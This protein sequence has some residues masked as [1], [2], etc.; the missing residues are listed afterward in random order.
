MSPRKPYRVK[1]RPVTW[2]NAD[3][4]SDPIVKLFGGTRGSLAIDYTQIPALIEQLERLQ[5]SHREIESAV[6]QLI[7]TD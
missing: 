2:T 7:I 3:G 4:T 6:E 1:A 5:D